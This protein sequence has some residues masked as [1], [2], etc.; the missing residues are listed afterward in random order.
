M[1]GLARSINA[2]EKSVQT[3]R[4]ASDR[5]GHGGAAGLIRLRQKGARNRRRQAQAQKTPPQRRRQ[6]TPPQAQGQGQEEC[7]SRRGAADD[8][9]R[10]TLIIRPCSP[11][12]FLPSPTSS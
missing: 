4:V 9:H 11:S 2:Y 3:P 1:A 10:L 8:P 7:M 12:S 5:A 6:E